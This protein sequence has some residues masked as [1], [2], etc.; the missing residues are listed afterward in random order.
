[1]NAFYTCY[2]TLITAAAL[3]ALLLCYKGQFKFL[4][5][6]FVLVATLM[7]EVASFI[8]FKYKIK[9]YNFIYYIF[10]LLEYTLFCLYYLRTCEN[11]KLKIPV[12]LSIPL[13]VAF[14]LYVAFFIKHF[15]G[16]PVLNI[17]VEGFLL[18]IIYTHLLFNLNVE[19]DQF[20]YTHVDFWISIGI[21][22]FF[23]G[24]FVFFGLY[25]ILHHIDASKAISMYGY[26]TKPLNLIFYTC[27]IIGL[28]CLILNKKYLT[29]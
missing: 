4:F 15:H 17:D 22:I 12:K 2:F 21:L 27:V 23:G 16:L 18:F 3:L 29:R 1:M 26:M 20:I 28:I 19:G 24:T 11:K 7:I 9:G 5:I 6:V 25:P 14:G 10:N 8:V 13:F